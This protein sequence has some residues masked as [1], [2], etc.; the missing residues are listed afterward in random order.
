MD[1]KTLRYN[2]GLSLTQVAKATGYSKSHVAS[3]ESGTTH[4][5]EAYSQI[6]SRVVKPLSVDG[7]SP[8][9]AIPAKIH[10]ELGS[11]TRRAS[12]KVNELQALTATAKEVAKLYEQITLLA[13]THLDTHNQAQETTDFNLMEVPAD[14]SKEAADH[15]VQTWLGILKQY[16]V[17]KLT[18]EDQD[19]VIDTI[20][21]LFK[22]GLKKLNSKD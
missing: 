19:Q 11:L 5:S 22:D 13:S 7:A 12:V 1:F 10:R 16:N 15:I 18:Q 2:A 9:Q 20:Q 6:F 14:E 4:P 17:H 21:I 3:V 8:N